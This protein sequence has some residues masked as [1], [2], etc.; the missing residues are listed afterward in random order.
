[1][2]NKRTIRQKIILYILSVFSLFYVISIGYIVIS[3]RQTILNETLEKTE[4]LAENSA[5]EISRFFE[6]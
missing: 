4:L 3:S 5:G 6:K 2:K 1:M